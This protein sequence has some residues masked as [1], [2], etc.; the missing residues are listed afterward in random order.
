MA[1]PGPWTLT[2]TARTDI[3]AG[4]SA[5]GTGYKVALVTSTSNISTASTTYAALTNEVSNANGYTTGGVAVTL[6]DTGTTSVALYFSVNPS[7]VASGS[8]IVART[9]VLYKIGG[10]II[11]FSVLDS[12]PADVTV[13]TGNTLTIKSDNTASNPVYTLA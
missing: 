1:A 2:N 12:T 13:S 10:N 9:A 8:G 11:A 6:A 7:W 4:N 5:I 3:I